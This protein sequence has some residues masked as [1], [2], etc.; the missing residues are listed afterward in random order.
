MRE[1][2]G[3]VEEILC[4]IHVCF[5]NICPP[6]TMC[7]V[8]VLHLQEWAGYCGV[9]G[10]QEDKQHNFR[11]RWDVTLSAENRV[12]QIKVGGKKF[13][14]CLKGKPACSSWGIRFDLAGI[15]SGPTEPG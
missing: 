9:V 14:F 8:L 11:Y 7:R 5:T 12:G 3:V 10:H 6:P 13:S 15:L 1:K 4:F 2:A